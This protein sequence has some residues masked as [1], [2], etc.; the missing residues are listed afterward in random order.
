MRKNWVSGTQR[1]AHGRADRAHDHVSQYREYEHGRSTGPHGRA[2][3]TVQ[4]FR[5]SPFRRFMHKI[6]TVYPISI[7]FSPTCSIHSNLSYSSVKIKFP[8]TKT[9]YSNLS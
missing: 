3:L 8:H 9:T 2:R 7:L 6:P 4:I 5:F 1:G